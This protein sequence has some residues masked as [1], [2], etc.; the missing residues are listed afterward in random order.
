MAAPSAARYRH[1]A[2]PRSDPLTPILAMIERLPAGAIDEVRRALRAKL[3]T[4]PTAAERRINELRFLAQLLD[5][6]PQPPGRAPYVARKLYDKRRAAEGSEPPPSGR[7]QRRFGSWARACQAAWGLLEDGRWIGDAQPWPRP[8]RRRKN[9]SVEE[10]RASV[11]QCRERVGHIPS[12]SEYHEWIGTRR[13]R[14]R[15]E[16]H[17]ISQFVLVSTVYR[18]LAPDR[19][20]RN[21]WRLVTE[22]VFGDQ[23]DGS[24]LI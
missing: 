13:A 19:A 2:A 8:A 14:A 18:L 12:S 6:Q 22:R 16:G 23:P 20:N 4:P 21:G 7:L 11:R 5:E 9:Y 10:A 24:S 1:V 15:A 3:N 17:D